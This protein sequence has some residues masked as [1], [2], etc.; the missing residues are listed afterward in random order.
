MWLQSQIWSNNARVVYL[1]LL[2]PLIL[3]S[4]VFLVMYFGDPYFQDL[5]QSDMEAYLGIITIMS[6]V[7]FLWLAV[8]VF[9]QRR[10]IFAFS[11]AKVVERKDYPEIYNL[12]ENLAISQWMV[13]PKLG[14]IQDASKNAFATGWWANDS[15]VVLSQG[16][17]NK[18]EKDEL[19]GVIAHELSHIKNNDVKVMVIITVFVWIIATIGEILIRSGTRRSGGDNKWSGQIVLIGFVLLLL[20]YLV[21]PLIN[22]AVSRRKEYLADAGSV[23]MTKNPDGLIRALQKISQDSRI[24][25]ITKQNIANMCIATPFERDSKKWFFSKLRWWF[26]THPPIEERIKVLEE[27]K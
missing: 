7:I 15:W 2:M 1:I 10:I 16:L 22:L 9:F 8:S 26:S 25:S 23:M 14:I 3:Y 19:E 24:E 27:W 12:L 20:G 5:S 17:I 21:F 18:L 11:G 4:V 6:V 13:T